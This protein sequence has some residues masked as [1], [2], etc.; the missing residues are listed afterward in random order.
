[1][2]TVKDAWVQAMVQ[3]LDG[4]L[5]IAEVSYKLL[6]KMNKGELPELAYRESEES[7]E[8]TDPDKVKEGLQL[9]IQEILNSFLEN[10]ALLE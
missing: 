8:V 1:M 4:N 9:R 5:T 10:G 2:V 3:M 7:E 6:E